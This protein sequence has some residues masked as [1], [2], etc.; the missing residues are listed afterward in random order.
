M[1]EPKVRTNC[2]AVWKS[3]LS[4]G[5]FLSW[6]PV[7]HCY[8]T[9]DNILKTAK[10]CFKLIHNFSFF[11]YPFFNRNCW[12]VNFQSFL[13]ISDIWKK[14]LWI[15]DWETKTFPNQINFRLCISYSQLTVN[16]RGITVADSKLI[17]TFLKQDNQAW[18]IYDCYNRFLQTESERGIG[19]DLARLSSG[20]PGRSN[21]KHCFTRCIKNMWHSTSGYMIATF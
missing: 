13:L 12:Q 2:A 20:I 3:F 8:T 9:R 17:K 21:Q 14:E 7:K 11:Q 10:L 16:C 1:F 4:L 19:T 6:S 5:F 15:Q 18:R